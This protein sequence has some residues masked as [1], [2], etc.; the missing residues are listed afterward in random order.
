VPA[1]AQPSVTRVASGRQ[2]LCMQVPLGSPA[3]AVAAD[4]APFLTPRTRY[5]NVDLQRCQRADRS[6]SP[7]QSGKD[8]L[9]PAGGAPAAARRAGGSPRAHL[10]EL[11]LEALQ[12]AA[13]R[14]S[15]VY[16]AFLNLRPARGWRPPVQ[17]RRCRCRPEM[18]R[19]RSAAP[20]Q[21]VQCGLCCHCGS[22]RSQR[23]PLHAA[24]ANSAPL[25]RRLGGRP[26][27]QL[28]A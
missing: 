1:A 15:S 13:G 19:R 23:S 28:H 10:A 27:A 6:A 8:S 20:K 12:L 2:P 16:M 22:A 3:H 26:P 9:T 18:R 4:T 5:A 11:R 14:N 17:Q 7:H 25:T 24:H 21:A